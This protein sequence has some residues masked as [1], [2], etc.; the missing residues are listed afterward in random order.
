MDGA[1]IEGKT[2][3]RFSSHHLK[4]QDAILRECPVSYVMNRTPYVYP[5]I[6]AHAHSGHSGIEILNAPTF[7]QQAFNVI[8]AEKVRLQRLADQDKQTKRDADYGKR[9]LLRGR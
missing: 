1:N 8:G 4:E 9:A 6:N 7:L 2:A 5:L 3:F